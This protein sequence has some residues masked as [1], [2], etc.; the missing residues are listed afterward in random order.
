MSWMGSFGIVVIL[1]ME[2]VIREWRNCDDCVD[3]RRDMGGDGGRGL[4]VIG[5]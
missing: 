4:K 1:G 3:G 2:G 5:E